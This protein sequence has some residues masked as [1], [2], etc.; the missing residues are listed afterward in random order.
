LNRDFKTIFDSLS[1]GILEVDETLRIIDCNRVAEGLFGD[2]LGKSIDEV[3]KVPGVFEIAECLLNKKNGEFQVELSAESSTKYMIINIRKNFLILKDITEKKILETAKTDFVNFFVHEISTPLAVVSGYAQLIFDRK[4]EI[5]PELS[6]AASGILK[7]SE[8]LSKL[9]EELGELANIE[10]GN[11]MVKREII[12]LKSLIEEI[13]EDFETKI[14]R[15]KLKIKTLVSPEHYVESDSLL[16]YRILANLVSNAVKY[17][18]DGG[19][20]EINAV[21]KDDEIQISVKDEGIGIERDEIHRIFERFYR[22][23]NAKKLSINGLG[24]G[25]SIV[26]HASDLIGAKIQVKSLPMLETVF[27]LRLPSTGKT[28]NTQ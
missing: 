12:H 7:S 23:T 20:I 13:I 28:L 1:D 15:K 10:L 25:L 18:L 5:P 19:N 4:D 9:I 17:S 22:G 11:Y 26:K 24:I 27:I 21:E 3:L 6:E 8:R 14:K 2:V 16:L